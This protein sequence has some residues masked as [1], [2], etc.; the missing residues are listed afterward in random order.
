M[1]LSTN[2][3]PS[4]LN[5]NRS[6][7]PSIWTVVYWATFLS[8]YLFQKSTNRRGILSYKCLV[9]GEG[10]RKRIG[11]KILFTDRQGTVGRTGVW[12]PVTRFLEKFLSWKTPVS[13]FFF[14]FFG[15]S[16]QSWKLFHMWQPHVKRV[17]KPCPLPLCSLSFLPQ[18]CSQVKDALVSV[19]FPHPT[20]GLTPVPPRSL[21]FSG[22]V[23]QSFS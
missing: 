17:H 13:Y 22:N 19:A 1:W 20:L 14:F 16:N 18:L 4:A 10:E 12:F 15:Q 23:T 5:A 6:L 7:S 8:D 11:G 3:V 21:C 9:C 2:G